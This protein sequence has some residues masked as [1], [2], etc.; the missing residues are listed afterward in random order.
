MQTIHNNMKIPN[1]I[2]NDNNKK[3]KKF[4]KI[5]NDAHLQKYKAENFNGDRIFNFSFSRVNLLNSII[6]DEYTLETE[7]LMKLN[8]LS[9]NCSIMYKCGNMN[10][11]KS[12]LRVIQ[13]NKET[14]TLDADPVGNLGFT[15]DRPDLFLCKLDKY[16]KGEKE[17]MFL[18]STLCNIKTLD[19]YLTNV[20]S[21]YKFCFE[22]YNL[23]DAKYIN[24][25]DKAL[26]DEL[27]LIGDKPLNTAQNVYDYICIAVKFWNCRINYINN[28][29]LNPKNEFKLIEL[30][31]VINKRN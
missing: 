29:F 31:D 20:G 8:H 18:N 14:D 24:T 11:T 25:V 19:I 2:K 27:L 23:V 22:V 17:T 4:Y 21:V 26:V 28:N 13:Y 10:N 30:E 9:V 5:M 16:Y 6:K 12:Q 15:L 1:K 3:A 7:Y